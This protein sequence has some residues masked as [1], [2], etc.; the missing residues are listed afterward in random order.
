MLCLGKLPTVGTRPNTITSKGNGSPPDP[1]QPRQRGS[2]VSCLLKNR[3][4]SCGNSL[5]VKPAVIKEELE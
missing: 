3:A 1:K 5:D 4:T 2:S